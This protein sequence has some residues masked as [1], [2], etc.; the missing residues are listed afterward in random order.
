MLC[1][2][3][4]SFVVVFSLSLCCVV[5]F[6]RSVIVTV[7]L[8]LFCRCAVLSLCCLCVVLSLCSLCVVM[9]LFCVVI[10]L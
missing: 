10:V 9:S 5:L 2:R 7:V 3:C 4:L 6:R 1:C 8:S